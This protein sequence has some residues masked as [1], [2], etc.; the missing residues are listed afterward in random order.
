LTSKIRLQA[1]ID[2]YNLFNVNSVRGVTSTYGANWQ[3][4]T[5]ILDPRLI[6]LSGSLNF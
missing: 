5:Q 6:Q 3:R 4:P 1:N 2:A